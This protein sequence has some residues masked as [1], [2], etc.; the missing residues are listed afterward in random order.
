MVELKLYKGNE[1][2]MKF[3]VRKEII[4]IGRSSQ[5]DICLPDSN[6]SRFH[7]AVSAK[8]NKY[9][10]TDK[11]TNGT[12]VNSKRIYSHELKDSDEIKIGNWVIKF[13]MTD[14]ESFEGSTQVVDKDPTR[15]ISYK[16]D[17]NEIVIEKA[18]LRFETDKVK[19]FPITKSLISIGKAKA[20][21]IIVNDEYISNFHTKIEN[22]RGEFFIKDLGSTNGTFVNGQKIFE[23]SL[24]FNSVI[25]IGKTI[26]K[27]YTENERRK[28]TPTKE[29]SFMG[30]VGKSEEMRNIFSLIS[31][32][33][34]SD[35]TVLVQGETGTGKELVA[36][37]IHKL[38]GRGNKPFVTVNCG[39]IS[40]DLIE[41]ELFGHEKGAFTSAHQQRQG[42]FESA[43]TGTIFLDEI[44]ELPLELQPKLLRVLEN[45]EI[46]RVGGNELIDLDVR[47]ISA[48]NKNLAYEV[49]SGK[50]REDLYYRLMIIPI[51]IPPLR[52]RPEDVDLL[53]E[54][55][56]SQ[57][58]SKGK[59]IVQKISPRALEILKK[60]KWGGN[61]R[62][63]KNL[64]ARVILECTS[65]TIEPADLKFAPSSL[66]EQTA[67]EFNLSEFK[68]TKTV[69]TLRD[70]E[71]DKIT[72]ELKKN[73]WNR[74]ATAK[75]LGISKSTLHEK[76][77]KYN[78]DNRG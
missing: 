37:A 54:L 70:V 44:G 32:I 74:V 17:K 58:I 48:T 20:N 19:I 56:L 14:E 51:F 15:I 21:D 4:S 72:I 29:T 62:E 78:L 3:L 8:D 57:E 73:N 5:N 53:T 55:F 42:A 49:K 61:V 64:L 34:N 26:L 22:K 18:L 7:L 46:K 60:E 16:P 25:E 40:K 31:K 52:E 27:F 10:V 47:I 66:I 2:M 65:E 9:V 43:N 24:P 63:L 13:S 76:I 30:I 50:F 71:K 28:L 23:T 59:S 69:K 39:A 38:S 45:K 11:S 41:S 12:F 75:A 1:E 68:D 35:S 36:S 67:H 77:K 33:A 6:I